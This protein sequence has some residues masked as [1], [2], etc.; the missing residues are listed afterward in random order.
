M[1]GA[2]AAL[3]IGRSFPL[4]LLINKAIVGK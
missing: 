3:I 4:I 2:I 1:K